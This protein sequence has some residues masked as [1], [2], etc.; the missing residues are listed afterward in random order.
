[1]WGIRGWALSL[2]QPPVHGA[3][4]RVRCPFSMGAKG[5]GVGTRHQ[6]HSE[7][8]R[9]LAT[10]SALA[11]WLC[12]AWGRHMG[13]RGG[14]SFL[15]VRRPGLGAL[16][17]PAARPLGRRP[18]PAARFPLAREVWVWGTVTNPTARALAS[19][20]C[21]VWGRNE[22]GQGGWG[23]PFALVWAVRGRAL[24][25][26]QPPVHGAAGR[27]PLAVF[28]ERGGCGRGDRSLTHQPRSCEL[29]LRAVGAA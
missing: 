15:G 16:P 4:G 10:A 5:A 12:A 3:G 2:P 20:L 18:G 26:P 7:R 23:A 1:M 22:G 13:V 27:G 8:S 21:A 19:W 14:T 6:P 28:F 24:S 29:A 17:S 9:E 25:L 11:S